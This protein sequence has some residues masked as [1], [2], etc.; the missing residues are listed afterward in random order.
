MLESALMW[1][2][3]SGMVILDTA[4]SSLRNSGVAEMR[5]RRED[6]SKVTGREVLLAPSMSFAYVVLY[7]SHYWLRYVGI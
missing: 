3:V 1:G 6:I 2:R 5:V 7:L 4:D